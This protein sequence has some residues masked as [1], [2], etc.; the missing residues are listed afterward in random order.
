VPEDGRVLFSGSFQSGFNIPEQAKN[1]SRRYI[2]HSMAP[3]FDVL[4]L[5]ANT[6]RPKKP[7]PPAVPALFTGI[8]KQIIFVKDYDT[9]F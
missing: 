1:L 3:V 7:E 8:N 2:R 9:N 4:V 5:P 6:C